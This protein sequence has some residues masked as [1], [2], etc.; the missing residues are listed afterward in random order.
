MSIKFWI[1][2]GYAE[3]LW[4]EYHSALNSHLVVLVL[5]VLCLYEFKSTTE[6]KIKI[7]YQRYNKTIH[8]CE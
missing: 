5:V 4:I 7:F 3:K 6:I 8:K 1:W 2:M